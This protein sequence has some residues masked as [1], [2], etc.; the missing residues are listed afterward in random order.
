GRDLLAVEATVFDEDF[1]GARTCHD[2]TSHIYAWN[3]ALKGHGIAHR[4]TLLCREFNTHGAKEIV[5][6]VISSEGE[7]EVILD[8]DFAFGSLQDYMVEGNLLHGGVEVSRDLAVFDAIF[9]VRTNPIL[10]MR[11]HPGP[12]VNQGDARSMTPQVQG[13]NG[14][15]V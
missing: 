4:P 5:I 3:I 10:H 6:G 1:I 2:H 7:H 9:N 11:M 13:G 15:R 12:A 8:G 14:C